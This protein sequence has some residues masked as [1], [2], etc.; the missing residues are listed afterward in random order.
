MASM[1][2]LRATTR[3]AE[4]FERALRVLVDGVSSPSRGPVNYSPY[5]LF[6][7]SGKGAELTDVD[8]NRYV[9]IMLGYGSLIHGHAHPR[10]VEVAQQAVEQGALFATASEIEIE[11]AER[12][13]QMVPHIE[14]VRFASTGTEAAMAALRL[15]RGFTGRSKFIKFEGHYHGWCDAYS[16]SSNATPTSVVEQPGGPAQ[17]LDTLGLSLGS[18][19][20]TI[21]VPWNDPDPVEDALRRYSGEVAMIVTEP[22]MA[23]MGV[24]P[25]RTGF[26][27][28]LRQ[29]ADRYGV[30]L[31]LDETVTGFRVAGGGAQELFGVAG[32]IVT[33]GK[34]LG[35]GFPVAAI[36]GRSEVMDAFAR[37]RVYHA[38]TQNAN[39]A[40]L[41]VVRES[42][43]L[44]R[45]DDGAAFRRLDGL[46]ERLVVGLRHAI[47]RSRHAAIVQNV[48]AL[49]QIF[50]L[51]PGHESTEEIR[52]MAAFRANVDT[53][54]FARFAHVMFDHGV[55]MSP[56]ASLNSVLS[57]VH[58][59][60]DVD[61][62]VAA[63]AD[64]LLDLPSSIRPTLDQRVVTR[65]RAAR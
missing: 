61:H 49:L 33:F 14:R 4:L 13:C 5:P 46:A 65:K 1:D 43:D 35:A 52:D 29:L 17:Y 55:Y 60:G 38:G 42:L 40:L 58:T 56:S 10:L 20:D 6:M 51:L 18:V 48:G 30:L 12:I 22:V 63:A 28:A 45:D 26:L 31:Y 54:K 44:L 16:L 37:G 24:I 34:A 41:Q 21:V 36:G 39:P 62:I 2:R 57:T 59:V 64:S 9:D 23:N 47:A 11:V 7:H 32:D 3:S 15:A 8:G 53:Q 27:Q 19:R 50:F 25:P